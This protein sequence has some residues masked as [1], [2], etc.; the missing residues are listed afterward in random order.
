MKLDGSRLLPG[1]RPDVWRALNDPELLKACIPGCELLTGNANE[2]FEM[3]IVAS[4]GPVRARL[5]GRLGM[6]DV[7]VDESYTLKFDLRGGAA[8]FGRGELQ[9]RL[10]DEPCGS[11]LYYVADARVGGRIAQLGARLIEGTARRLS[12]EFFERFA[13]QIALRSEATGTLP[14]AMADRSPRA[15]RSGVWIGVCVAVSASL[16]AA[17]LAWLFT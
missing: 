15:I 9:V 1:K 2:S 11:S 7:I 10:Q 12:E 16:G 4:V 6:T 13:T 3:R 14:D 5:S 17:A 8:G